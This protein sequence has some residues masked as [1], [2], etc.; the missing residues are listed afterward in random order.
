MLIRVYGDSLGMP[1]L[2][3]QIPYHATYAEL[4]SEECR[5]LYP[6]KE[7]H[8]YNRSRGA[9]TVRSLIADY[10]QDTSYFG[11]GETD[12]LVI[13]C[14]I[15]DCAPRPIP[16]A[17]RTAVGKLP[18]PLRKTVIA[19]LHNNRSWLVRLGPPWREVRASS[20]LKTYKYWLQQAAGQCGQVF[21]INIAPTTNEIESHSPGL[22]KSIE[23][24]NRLIAQA[25]QE[26]E[27]T[28]VVLVD[29]YGAIHASGSAQYVNQEDGHH[30]TLRGHEL[31]G[32]L[33]TSSVRENVVGRRPLAAMAG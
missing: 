7:V 4:L 26:A 9:G 5:R 18:G 22:Q 12:I 10:L 2:G 6:G 27:A 16:P 3:D 33:L 21:A 1:R 29:A 13:Q 23:L 17:A 19:G 30:L 32:D 20:F 15:C 31:Y 25:V 14:G 24:Y 28:N 11:T 8:L